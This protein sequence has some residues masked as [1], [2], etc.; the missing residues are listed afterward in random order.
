MDEKIKSVV[1]VDT[2]QET[3]PEPVPELPTEVWADGF[4]P[5]AEP[6]KA[7]R[8]EVLQARVQAKGSFREELLAYLGSKKLHQWIS[9][10]DFFTSF[11]GKE[12]STRDAARAAKFELDALVAEQKIVIQ[13]NYHQALNLP[14]YQHGDPQTRYKTLN[15]INID[16]KLFTL[17]EI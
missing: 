7:V 10:K 11:Y 2:P 16:G 8:A 9:L 13:N 15:E 12:Y 5:V 3:K 6:A 4:S 14:Y 1:V 17:D